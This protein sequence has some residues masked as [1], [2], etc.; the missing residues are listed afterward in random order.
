M[1]EG[2]GNW[3]RLE[4]ELGESGVG[5]GRDGDSNWEKLEWKLGK[6]WSGKWKKMGV[7]DI[8]CGSPIP[9]VSDL[10]IPKNLRGAG[11]WDILAQKP[12]NDSL[13]L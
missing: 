3:E 7:K 12:S 10:V 1:R 6:N 2:N 5:T 13:T 9:S 11:T 4:W 8:R